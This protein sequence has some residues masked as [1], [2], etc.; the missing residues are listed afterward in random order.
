MKSTRYKWLLYL[1]H[2]Y[3]TA[4]FVLFSIHFFNTHWVMSVIA[5]L[6][7]LVMVLPMKSLVNFMDSGKPHKKT[8]AI[9]SILLACFAVGIVLGDSASLP[10]VSCFLMIYV[11]VDLAY[12]LLKF[13]S[14]RKEA[15]HTL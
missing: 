14:Y 9:D 10:V 13:L 11:A 1:N 8:I 4:G 12:N 2:G 7:A 6:A 3:L 5:A 15:G